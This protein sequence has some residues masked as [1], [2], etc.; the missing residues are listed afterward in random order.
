[1]QTCFDHTNMKFMY[2]SHSICTT[3][4]NIWCRLLTSSDGVYW[5][6]YVMLLMFIV[7][8]KVVDKRMAVIAH[9]RLSLM[10]FNV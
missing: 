10:L 7:V 9:M 5:S 1:M 8:E 6:A 4:M 2:I 3:T